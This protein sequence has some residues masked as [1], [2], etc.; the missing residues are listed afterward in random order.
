MTSST[1]SSWEDF[2]RNDKSHR[3]WTECVEGLLQAEYQYTILF[4]LMPIEIAHGAETCRHT[5]KSTKLEA[6]A[7]KTTYAQCEEVS[8]GRQSNYYNDIPSGANTVRRVKERGGV[9]SRAITNDI[10]DEPC[11]NRSSKRAD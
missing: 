2:G 5:K 7:T 11:D 1:H 9:S 4:S 3:P 8:W 10:I 6:A